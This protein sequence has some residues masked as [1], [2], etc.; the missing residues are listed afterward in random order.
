MPVVHQ[1]FTIANQAI[2]AFCRSTIK[3]HACKESTETARITTL[4]LM[5]QEEQQNSPHTLQ[6]RIEDTELA[7]ARLK[8]ENNRLSTSLAEATERAEAAELM[9]SRFLANIS[10][11]IRT[12]MNGILGMTE[13][14]LG[15]EL[16]P[17]QLKFTK[18]IS[19]STESLLHVVNDMLDFSHLHNGKLR[20]ED[21][22]FFFAKTVQEVCQQYRKMAESKNINIIC[23]TETRLQVPVIGD[24]FRIRQVISNLLDN[25]IKFTEQGEVTITE[26]ANPDSGKHTVTISDTG[27]GIPKEVQSEIF[28]SFAQADNSSTRKYG[29][30]GLGLSIANQLAQLMGGDIS[31]QSEL[32]SGSQFTFSC[33]LRE[34]SI[35]SINEVGKNL[36]EGTRVLV[37]DDTETNLEILSLQLQQWNLEVHCAESG[38]EALTLLDQAAENGKPFQL[39]ILDLNMP[40]MD[41]LELAQH[42][43]KA[44]YARDLR[45]MMLTSSVIDLNAKALQEHGI[46]KSM[47]KPARQALLYDSITKIILEKD[48][49]ETLPAPDR[50]TRILLTED[51]P[52]NQEVATIMLESM[53]YEVVIANNGADA[54]DTMLQDE[55]IDLILMDCQMPVMD[56]FNA[57][58][59]IR[60]NNVNTPI[61]ALTANAMQGDKDLCL[62]AGMNDYLTKP[63]FQTDLSRVVQQWVSS[64]AT[65]TDNQ[66]DT[67]TATET[68]SRENIMNIE[69]DESALDAIRSLQRPG[70]PD[71]LAR[72]VN[73]YME[74]SPELIAAIQEGVA[75]NDC[76]KVKMAAHTLKS[77]SAYVGASAL[78]EV[79]SQVESKASNDQLTDTSED[80]DNISNGFASV[81]TQI[82]QYG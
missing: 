19:K 70:K 6:Q 73:M 4:I 26:S 23:N 66:N 8:E 5:S 34:G 78:A 15:T 61:V 47:M 75:A 76:D 44:D 48:T 77:S 31:I 79:C 35:D 55:N 46:V 54:V 18:S 30:T 16:N 42:I 43:Q 60:N 22:V 25:A 52:I 28:K 33:T 57:T 69:I 24:E 20:L 82:K 12:P 56:G 45:V 7:S 3:S 41:G 53:G 2:T 36:L 64:T 37:V 39:A 58:R 71:I 68:S 21:S 63:I 51:D 40:N 80:I 1:Q 32:D 29:G 11:E 74:K 72:I 14:L 59:A 17:E 65:D 9:K 10:H 50:T 49:A 67:E 27:A 13:L 62:D 38:V 81:V